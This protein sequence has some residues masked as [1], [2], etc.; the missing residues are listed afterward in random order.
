MALLTDRCPLEWATNGRK[1]RAAKRDDAF[2][3]PQREEEMQGTPQ[4][5][6]TEGRARKNIA[7]RRDG[8]QGQRKHRR[9]NG[10]QTRR[11]GERGGDH[12]ERKK[13]NCGVNRREMMEEGREW[14]GSAGIYVE[15]T[16]HSCKW[17]PSSHGGGMWQCGGVVGW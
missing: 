2:E 16:W 3:K 13:E 1:K 14:E 12:R 4:R 10:R 11:A 15:T 8:G 9:E 5:G 7:E 6:D 17:R